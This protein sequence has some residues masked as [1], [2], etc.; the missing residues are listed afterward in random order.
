MSFLDLPGL[1]SA[2]LQN[3]LL[4][5]EPGGARFT[6]V[7]PFHQNLQAKTATSWMSRGFAAAL[8]AAAAAALLHVSPQQLMG[9]SVRVKPETNTDSHRGA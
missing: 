1:F 7:F 5:P 2:N 3:V 8:V 4:Q 9:A 6:T